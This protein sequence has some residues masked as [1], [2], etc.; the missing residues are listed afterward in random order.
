[1]VAC[2]PRDSSIVYTAANRYELQIE[3]KPTVLQ[4]ESIFMF[5]LHKLL[6]VPIKWRELAGH[7]PI[8][9]AL[10]DAIDTIDRIAYIALNDFELFFDNLSHCV[11][12]Q[13]H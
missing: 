10:R 1:M 12:K 2:S 11:L 4:H 9:C 8:P 6:A 13:K 3:K 7:C 5:R